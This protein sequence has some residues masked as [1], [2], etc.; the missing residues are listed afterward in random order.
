MPTAA[1]GIDCE[2]CGL[3]L[4][5]VCAS[6][7][8]GTSAEGRNKMETQKKLFGSPC[9]VLACAQMNRV[10][11]CLR[12]CRAFP[13]ENFSSGPYPFS[14][15]F[16]QMQ[17][18]RRSKETQITDSLEKTRVPAEFWGDLEL[19]DLK[20]ICRNTL[21]TPVEGGLITHFAHRELR[22]DLKKRSISYSDGQLADNLIT[23]IT[24]H[25]LLHEGNPPFQN[26]MVAPQDL[27]EGHF[28][29]G[30]HE[31]ST[32]KLLKRFGDD[33]EAFSA[34]GK[35]LGGTILKLADAAFRIMVFPKIPVYYLLWCRDEEF[36]SRLSILF[37]RSIEDHLSA[38]AIWGMVNRVSDL[39]TEK[40]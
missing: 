4:S 29:Q 3:F 32:D 22:V 18:R 33:P 36:P 28:F 31:L 21:S 14:E 7:G 20:E 24:L 39:L 37:D 38:D 34:A 11:Y 35:N 1:C 13:C 8:S 23:L 5:G 26:E 17:T 16:L 25:Y 2:V 9:P 6:C 27:K 12:D 30:P 10:E 19:K 40:G 15:G